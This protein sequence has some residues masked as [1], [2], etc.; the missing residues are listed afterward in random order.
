MAAR[1][2]LAERVVGVREIE[3]AEL[4]GEHQRGLLARRAAEQIVFE[5]AP[6]VDVVVP[7]RREQTDAVRRRVVAPGRLRFLPASQR[8]S[9]LLARAAERVVA[10]E[11]R[12]EGADPFADDEAACVVA[13]LAPADVRIG[14]PDAAAE[15]VVVDTARVAVMIGDARELVA[16]VVLVA[17]DPGLGARDL[18][19]ALDAAERVALHAHHVAVRIGLLDDPAIVT[20]RMNATGTGQRRALHAVERIVGVAGRGAGGAEARLCRG[21]D[22]AHPIVRDRGLRNGP[23]ARA[24]AL[25]R[26]DAAESVV[27]RRRRARAGGGRRARLGRRDGERRVGV[28]PGRRREIRGRGFAD[29]AAEHVVA[30]VGVGARREIVGAADLA[31][32]SR[33]AALRDRASGRRRVGDLAS[34]TERVDDGGGEGVIGGVVLRRRGAAALAGVGARIG[35]AD[36]IAIGVVREAGGGIGLR[37]IAQYVDAAREV[38]DRRRRAAAGIAVVREARLANDRAGSGRRAA[39]QDLRL[40]AIDEVERVV[41][42]V[43]EL[44]GAGVA[45]YQIG[46]ARVDLAPLGD[47]GRIAVG[48]V[49]IRRPGD[50]RRRLAVVVAALDV[51]EQRGVRRRRVLDVVVRDV[52]PGLTA[53]ADDRL[54]REPARQRVALMEGADRA[55]AVG[56]RLGD[57]G[58]AAKLACGAVVE[59]TAVR[60]GRRPADVVRPARRRVQRDGGHHGH[61]ER[62][63]GNPAGVECVLDGRDLV[64]VV[65]ARA[66][67]RGHVRQKIRKRA[68]VPVDLV[69]AVGGADEIGHAVG[70]DVDEAHARIEPG[71]VDELEPG[72]NGPGGAPHPW[73]RRRLVDVAVIQPGGALVAHLRADQIDAPVAVHVGEAQA[74]VARVGRSEL[75]EIEPARQ[76]PGRRLDVAALAAVDPRRGRGA[77]AVGV[78]AR[79]DRVGESVAVE[80]DVDGAEFPVDQPEPGEGSPDRIDEADRLRLVVEDLVR[81]AEVVV[82]VAVLEVHR[83]ALERRLTVRTRRVGDGRALETQAAAILEVVVGEPLV[84][85]VPAGRRQ[86]RG[87]ARGEVAVLGASHHEL[88]QPVAVEIGEARV[89]RRRAT[90][91]VRVDDV[92]DPRAVHAPEIVGE[93]VA[94]V[95]GGHEAEAGRT[96]I[97]RRH[98]VER[99]RAARRVE[100]AHAA[101]EIGASVAGDVEHVE[102]GG[103]RRA[104]E[105]PGQREGN[106]A[107]LSG[108]GRKRV[109]GARHVG[110]AAAGIQVDPAVGGEREDRARGIGIAERRERL[111]E[112]GARVAVDVGEPHALVLPA[113]VDQRDARRPAPARALPA[114]RP[115]RDVRVVRERRDEGRPRR[116]GSRVAAIARHRLEQRAEGVG[117]LRVAEVVAAHERRTDL[118]VDEIESVREARRE[119]GAT[120]LGDVAARRALE[121]ELDAAILRRRAVETLERAARRTPQRVA[122]RREV[123]GAGIA[124]VVARGEGVAV[125]V[126]LFLEEPLEHLARGVRDAR[127]RRHA[128]AHRDAVLARH[129]PA[130][131]GLVHDAHEALAQRVIAARQG[132]VRALGDQLLAGQLEDVGRVVVAGR[133]ERER[134]GDRGKAERPAAAD[135]RVAARL[136]AI[137]KRERG[138]H[139]AGGGRHLDRDLVRG[140]TRERIGRGRRGDRR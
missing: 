63:A 46:A 122:D 22:A 106:L 9:A 44:A 91:D 45:G 35:D 87:T 75:V 10:P 11:D 119:A 55:T 136:A 1:D 40:H 3:V 32:P 8:G 20:A 47:R 51:R 56:P 83:D 26:D 21:D 117:A 29:E 81:A 52:E 104:G 27:A 59:A 109:R 139:A 124:A 17:G 129:G 101:D 69:H 4:V 6:G 137:A 93:D 89:S 77:V 99:P 112:I 34:V 70:V 16:R 82:Q 62:Q 33:A 85:T 58:E 118:D 64:V 133:A 31:D 68:A 128:E 7:A 103:A 138:R 94:E 114:R 42:E 60:V 121:H 86:R 53:G 43:A 126:F 12:L 84:E 123:G 88:R 49:A 65:G 98:S 95:V 132:G 135:P 66:G 2:E 131:V 92:H 120:A 19:D 127:L 80:V 102:P 105:G 24:V 74:R 113:R 48:V 30:A 130:S 67:G 125:A 76:R 115:R 18:L 73:C 100:V 96:A 140:R 5:H 25:D 38:A 39:A 13:E 36:E 97:P 71:G 116:R 23:P 54:A 110:E 79:R 90:R 41:R 107:V 57:A 28:A 111:H 134:A 15:A 37:R 14:D 108:E 61:D 72:R 78:V 50:A